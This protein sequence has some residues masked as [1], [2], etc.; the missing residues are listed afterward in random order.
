MY[1][2][3][4]K[5]LGT[6]DFIP[7][8][9]DLCAL[10]SGDGINTVQQIGDEQSGPMKHEAAGKI[11]KKK[12]KGEEGGKSDDTIRQAI[13][14]YVSSNPVGKIAEKA[15]CRSVFWQYATVFLVPN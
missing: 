14:L 8:D 12:C 10:I 15:V 4:A 5:E 11:F 7:T 13:D 9:S 1:Y 3:I 2:N 6:V